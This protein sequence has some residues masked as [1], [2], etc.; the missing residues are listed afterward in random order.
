MCIYIKLYKKSIVSE[1]DIITIK[2]LAEVMAPSQKVIHKVQKLVVLQIKEAKTANYL[3]TITD[4]LKIVQHAYPEE[5]IMPLGEVDAVLQY[6]PT[7]PKHNKIV[8]FFKILIVAA[9]IFAGSTVAIMA[10]Q[11]DTAFE[12]TLS[13]LNKIFTGYIDPD[14]LWITIPYSI[15]MPIGVMLFFNHIGTKRFSDDP[16]PIEIEIEKYEDSL[17]STIL[18]DLT[19]KRRNGEGDK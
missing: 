1:K 6:S 13:T 17:E 9:I 10:Y 18:D 7:K 12:R 5:Q 8:E 16:T 19:N 14:P 15:G 4:I 11:I 3:I 2:D